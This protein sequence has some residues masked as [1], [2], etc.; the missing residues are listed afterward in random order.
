MSSS[1]R[2]ASIALFTSA[3]L[4]AGA[5]QASS[6]SDELAE[7][8][9]KNTSSA[10]RTTFLQWAY[11]TLGKTQAAKSVATIPSAKTTAVEKQAQTALT[12]LVM[13]SCPKPAMN[14]LL[15]DPKKG[16]ENTLTSLAG[17]LVQEEVQKRSSPLLSLT[18]TDLLGK[19]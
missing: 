6:A 8:L 5:A 7:C 19:R 2:L 14:L 16:L 15:K 12:K 10:D 1:S 18:I 3:A 11:V 4:C 13:N 9:Y 17:L